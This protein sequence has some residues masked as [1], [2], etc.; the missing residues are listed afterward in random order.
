MKNRRFMSRKKCF[1]KGITA[2]LAMILSM[3]LTFPPG[4]AFAFEKTA[5][6]LRAEARLKK[7]ESLRLALQEDGGVPLPSLNKYVEDEDAL[8]I[9]GKAL[10]WDRRV[11]SDNITACAS[12]HFHAGADN[13]VKNQLNPDIL[14]IENVRDVDPDEELIKGFFYAAGAPDF[15]FSHPV[16]DFGPNYTLVR[17]DF[18]FV[19]QVG[20]GDNVVEVNGTLGP[21]YGNTNDVASSQGVFLTK[22]TGI[23][24]K[25]DPNLNTDTG[26]AELDPVWNVDGVVVRRVEPRN[27]PTVIN[28]VFNFANFWDGRANPSFNGSNPFGRNDTGARILVAQGKKVSEK[29]VDLKPASL[30][31]QAVGPPL[32]KF[33]MSFFG[34]SWP[35]IGKKMVEMNPLQGQEIHPN[36]S[37]LPD[38]F[39]GTTYADLIKAAFKSELWD[40]DQLIELGAPDTFTFLQGQDSFAQRNGA[41]TVIDPKAAKK[42]NNAANTFSLMEANFSFFFGIAVMFYQATLISD[43][44][45]FDLWMEAEGDTVVEGFGQEEMFGLDVFLNKGKCVNCHGGPEFTNASVRNA[46][47]GDNVI[48]PMIMGDLNAAFYD[49]GF[50]NIGVTPTVEDIGRGGADEF[51]F[52]LSWSRQ[53]LFQ[54][55]GFLSKG[56]PPQPINFRIFGLPKQGLVC[57]PD[58]VDKKGNCKNDILGFIDADTGEFFPVCEDNDGD[59]ACGPGGEDGE[60]IP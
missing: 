2:L 20:D 10:F 52:P 7:L 45:P 55:E 37:V 31:S 4:M 34:R 3:T 32:S 56:D 17:D 36:D 24:E 11:G 40:S 43:Q 8:L 16:A 51:G 30:A 19:T 6:E 39:D 18:P 15:E 59:G 26:I 48:E 14:R 60:D 50:Y 46:Q 13:R 38:D 27:T 1:K 21:A 47:N 53:Y 57:E 22:F 12:C 23:D 41:F 49:N 33:E 5:D 58:K 28:A 25:L 54:A 35:D 9:L 44:S 29:I 42:L